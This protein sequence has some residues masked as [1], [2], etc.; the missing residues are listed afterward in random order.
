MSRGF[1]KLSPEARRAIAQKGALAK[2]AAVRAAKAPPPPYAHDFLTFLDEVE[3]SGPT[4][5]VWRVFWKAADGLPLD[6][7]EL[8]IFQRHT[9]RQ[10]APTARARSCWVPAGRRGG[11]SD[12]VT[13]RATWRS[14]SRDWTKVLTRG[15]VGIIPLIAAD[16]DQA[17]NTL[18]Y[19]KGLA[20]HPLVKPHVKEVTKYAVQFRTG[21]IVRVVTASYRAARGYTML[22]AILEEC[23]FY[24]VEGSANPDE[25]ILAAIKP[26]LLTIPDARIYAISSPY[27][28]RGI[29]WNAYEK[30][31]AQDG[32][33]VLVFCADSLSLNPTL[34]PEE[35]A[36][37]FEDDAA[38]AGAE[39]GRDGLVSFR[40]DVEALYNLDTVRACVVNGRRELPPVE[41]TRYVGF[42]DMSGGSLDSASLAIG[43][44]EN[45]AAVLDL[46][47]ERKSPHDPDKVVGEF[48]ADLQRYRVREVTGDR[49]SAEWVRT[50]YERAGMTYRTSAR[51]KS[52]LYLELLPVV[53]AGQAALLEHGVLVA[54]LCSLE[55]R[56]SRGT[57]RDSVDHP[58][59]GRDDV[60]NAAAGALVVALERGRQA[61]TVSPISIP[62]MSNVWGPAGRPLRQRFP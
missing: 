50:S 19:L 35:I 7:E 46:L 5:A 17:H 52:E 32:S 25:E 55:R 23:A 14:I 41:G 48:S 47:R 10:A 21:A 30:H 51:T 60:A 42:V 57:G 1:G 28:R 27:S 2:A 39:Y 12:N 9:G 49:Y 15:E 56:T 26:A 22:D 61:V 38:R 6:A 40:K 24:Q 36:R 44:F 29:L 18:N 3:K 13:A 54:Q 33:D 4:R 16:K 8:A 53:N 43:H 37:E 31:W 45:G 11:K 34:P 20:E 59:G 62:R 58:K